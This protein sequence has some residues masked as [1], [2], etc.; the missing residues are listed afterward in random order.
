MKT[1]AILVNG[2][3]AHFITDIDLEMKVFTSSI[4]Y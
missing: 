2:G 4:C 3:V 1:M